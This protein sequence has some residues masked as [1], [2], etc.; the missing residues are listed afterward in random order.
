M[1]AWT[2][3]DDISSI[4]NHRVIFAQIWALLRSTKNAQHCLSI[5]QPPEYF[6]YNP[7]ACDAGDNLKELL[8]LDILD[9]C[10]RMANILNNPDRHRSFTSLKGKEAQTLL[11]LLQAVR[12][13]N[14]RRAFTHWFL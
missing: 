8:D 2:S 10:A 3:W 4:L 7:H 13:A 6:H 14:L 12:F 11:N 9:M 1:T 5:P